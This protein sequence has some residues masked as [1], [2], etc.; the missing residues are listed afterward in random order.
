MTQLF[1]WVKSILSQLIYKLIKLIDKVAHESLV[2]KS[3]LCFLHLIM[4]SIQE[5]IQLF[6]DC[7]DTARGRML[8]WL[9][10]LLLG[11]P[12]KYEFYSLQA[13]RII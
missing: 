6:T 10:E 11:D 7:V 5:E 2:E 12:C 13:D 8:K 9:E 3:P 4:T 1:D